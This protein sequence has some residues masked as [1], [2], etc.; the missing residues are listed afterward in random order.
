MIGI[1]T[2][3]T[4]VRDVSRSRS[5]VTATV[6][7]VLF[8]TGTTPKS[9]RL[10]SVIRKTSAMVEQGL[11][12]TLEPNCRSTAISLKVPAGPRYA[13]V[14]VRSKALQEEIISRKIALTAGPSK[15]RLSCLLY[16]SDAADE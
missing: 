8:S 11:A 10:F 4:M 9:V 7:C 3:P 12:S 6:P 14:V 15:F 1:D 2:S 13:T 5:S 16:T